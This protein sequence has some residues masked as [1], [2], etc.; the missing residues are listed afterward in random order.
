MT[1]N[2]ETQTKDITTAPDCDVHIAVDAAQ[3]QGDP[4][5]VQADPAISGMWRLGTELSTSTG[6]PVVVHTTLPVL[7]VAGS[8]FGGALLGVILVGVLLTVLRRRR[9][10]AQQQVTLPEGGADTTDGTS[11]VVTDGDQPS[12]KEE[13]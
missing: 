13:V 4:A 10:G 6:T 3:A 7:A 1:C 2:A 9:R 11:P 8:A 5:A 12:Q